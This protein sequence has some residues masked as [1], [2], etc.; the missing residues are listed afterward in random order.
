MRGHFPRGRA[1]PNL[2]APQRAQRGGAATKRGTAVPAV[3][4]TGG[5]PVPQNLR[6]T[7]R[8]RRL[9]LR[10]K[11]GGCSAPQAARAD[12]GSY[13]S[14][15][16]SPQSLIP[17]RTLIPNPQSLAEGGGSHEVSKSELW[18]LEHVKKSN[19]G[20]LSTV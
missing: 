20:L 15:V 11:T 5:T 17:S 18:C 14:L 10:R 9:V 12:G 13:T 6:A 3:P 1:A 19:F 16:P 4:V 2:I 8:F 7:Q